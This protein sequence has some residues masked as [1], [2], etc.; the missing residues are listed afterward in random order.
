MNLYIAFGQIHAHRV[1]G[2][3]FDKD[4]IARIKCEDYSEGRKIAFELFGNKFATDHSEES[5]KSILHF[6]PKGIEDA[7]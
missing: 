3:T 5:I 1:N 4:T 6:F 7:N 2:T